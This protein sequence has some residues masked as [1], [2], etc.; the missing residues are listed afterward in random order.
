MKLKQILFLIFATTVMLLALKQGIWGDR[1]ELSNLLSSSTERILE[2]NLENKS[3]FKIN[4]S[5]VMIISLFIAVGFIGCIC[6]AKKNGQ[7][8]LY[9]ERENKKKNKPMLE[10]ERVSV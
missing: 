2:K 1:E 8:F 9:K 7:F 10:K 5:A 6:L 4:F 3:E